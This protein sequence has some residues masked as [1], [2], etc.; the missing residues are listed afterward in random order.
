MVRT[1][2]SMD[3]PSYSTMYHSV[4]PTLSQALK[5]SGHL[6]VSG[7]IAEKRRGV[8]G[9]HV[10]GCRPAGILIDVSHLVRICRSHMPEIALHDDVLVGAREED[11]PDGGAFD[12]AKF[13]RDDNGTLSAFPGALVSPRYH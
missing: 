6:L 13:A 3:P 8:G 4:P 5:I 2:L 1:T 12:L 10:D 9:F 11:V 7:S